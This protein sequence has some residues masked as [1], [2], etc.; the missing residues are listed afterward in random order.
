MDKLLG[1]K[2]DYKE[3]ME[4]FDYD[5]LCL[6][7]A[8]SAYLDTRKHLEEEGLCP[9]SMMYLHDYVLTVEHLRK[10]NVRYNE[11]IRICVKD[12][13]GRLKETTIDTNTIIRYFEEIVK[14]HPE[15]KEQEIDLDELFKK[16]NV[17]EE[18]TKSLDPVEYTNLLQDLVDRNK[19]LEAITLNWEILPVKEGLKENEGQLPRRKYT[20]G[21]DTFDVEGRSNIFNSYIASLSPV[22]EL[23]GINNFDGYIAYVFNNSKVILEKPKGIKKSEYY[24]ATYVMDLNNFFELSKL[25]R[26]EIIEGLQSG[27]ITGVTRVYHTFDEKAQDPIEKYKKRIERHLSGS[28]YSKDKID[29][30]YAIIESERSKKDE[31]GYQRTR[32][33]EN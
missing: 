23:K 33:D 26:T 6:I 28:E 24:G 4:C 11:N 10:N 31:K 15:I 12:K 2:I 30:I 7:V 16:F 19:K 14:E 8:L 18:Y 20:P 3:F 5:K 25:S 27:D 21:V 29:S 32:T 17:T 1:A 22:L 13:N 9:G